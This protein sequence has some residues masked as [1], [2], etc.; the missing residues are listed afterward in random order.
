MKLGIITAY[1]TV[2]FNNIIDDITVASS[3]GT[4]RVEVMKTG[5]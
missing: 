1:K 2:K 3:R 5:G 4:N